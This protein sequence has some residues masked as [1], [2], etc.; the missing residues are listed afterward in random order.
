MLADLTEEQKILAQYMSD[1]SENCYCA[2]W[3]KDTEYILWHAVV[4]GPRKFGREMI[5]AQDIDRLKQWSVKTNSW[6]I[7]DDDQ[8]QIALTLQQW[9][10]RF[11]LEVK[12]NPG[13]LD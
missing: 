12:R 13:I 1:I 4:S 6:I 11:E 5:T 8:E 10:A 9:Q 7:F 3:L 2:G